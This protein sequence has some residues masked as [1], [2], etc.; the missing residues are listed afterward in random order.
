MCVLGVTTITERR[1]AD[2]L[3]TQEQGPL[4]APIF[5]LDIALQDGDSD[6]ARRIIRRLG[7]TRSG[8][9]VRASTFRVDYTYLEDRD[10]IAWKVEYIGFEDRN[11]ALEALA[12]DFDR[13]DSGWRDCFSIS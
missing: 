12:D 3:W 13:L 9:G 6:R 7:E 5:Y 10:A 8:K 1:C 11:A 4:V 2:R